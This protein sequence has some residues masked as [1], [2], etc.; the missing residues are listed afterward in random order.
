[1][2]YVMKGPRGLSVPTSL[3]STTHYV[4]ECLGREDRKDYS[5]SI[6]AAGSVY[7]IPSIERLIKIHCRKFGILTDENLSK[8][9]TFILTALR[10][11]F[12]SEGAIKVE[13]EKEFDIKLD[14]IHLY[15]FI[16]KL[17]YYKDKVKIT[18]YKSGSKPNKDAIPIQALLY[19]LIQKVQNPELKREIEFQYLKYPIATLV[20]YD[21]S[22]DDKL[23]GFLEWL[24]SIA[25][26]MESFTPSQS[27]SN[28]AKNNGN[29]FLCGVVG[30]KDNKEPKHLCQW[31]YPRIFFILKD[32]SGRQVESSFEKKDLEKKLKPGYNIEMKTHAGCPAWKHEWES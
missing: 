7:C 26:N 19:E 6:L 10:N 1:M 24:K 30:E 20:K 22:S 2:N 12:Y 31:K 15:G 18:D 21:Q 28:M 9:N 4:L 3:G 17:S 27:C 25:A 32:A 29:R 13:H 23:G 14:N 5:K 11:D 8:V 16:D